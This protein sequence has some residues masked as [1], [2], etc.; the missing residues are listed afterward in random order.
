[1][2]TKPTGRPPGRPKKDQPSRPPRKPGRPPLPLA[3][4]PN[5]Y[6]IALLQAAFDRG[7]AAGISERR[8]IETFAGLKYGRPIPAP[9][10]LEAMERG[11]R[12]AVFT[13]LHRGDPQGFDWR[14]RN[15]FRAIGDSCRLNVRRRRKDPAIDADAR[16]LAHM[17]WADRI[18]RER[19]V[20]FED[21]AEYLAEEVGELDFFNRE[22]RP[23][24]RELRAPGFSRIK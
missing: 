12:Y 24:L 5:R 4:D 19:R 7:H 17:S 21:L 1:V 10:N 14:N 13:T 6:E 22:M 18:C 3:E 20:E 9:E 2:V 15:S 8:I 11:E 16:W 23:M